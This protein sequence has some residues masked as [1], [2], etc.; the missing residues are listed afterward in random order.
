MSLPS[1]PEGERYPLRVRAYWIVSRKQS[2]ASGRTVSVARES[3][4]DRLTETIAG[5]GQNRTR[6]ALG[7]IILDCP[8]AAR[9]VGKASR[10]GFQQSLILA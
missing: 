6:H 8:S 7:A 10:A 9:D 4:L 5:L 2:P 1:P 3:V